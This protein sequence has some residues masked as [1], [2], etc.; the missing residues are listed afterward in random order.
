L[1]EEINDEPPCSYPIYFKRCLSQIASWITIDMAWYS[2]SVVQREIVS[3]FL[4][5]QEIALEPM[6]NT[7]VEVDFLLS[8]SPP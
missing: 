4:E 2:T 5:A 6:L 3:Y 8:L 7:Y 1:F